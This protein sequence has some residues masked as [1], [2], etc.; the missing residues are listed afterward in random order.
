MLDASCTYTAGFEITASD[1]TLDCRGALVSST[2]RDGVGIEVSTPVDTDLSGVTI[3]NCRV[4]G[5][6]NSMRVT[7]VGFRTLTAGHEYD[8]GISGVVIEDS[9]IGG[10]AGVGIYVDA[11]VTRTTIRTQHDRGRGEHRDLPR[12]RDRPTTWSST[13]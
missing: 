5:F 7:R 10:S 2:S 11:Y 9:N 13:T 3:R 6:L 1:V 4:R 8:H 12:G